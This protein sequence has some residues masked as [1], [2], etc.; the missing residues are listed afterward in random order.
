M[1]P[2]RKAA[3][4]SGLV[5][6]DDEDVMQMGANEDA[7]PQEPLDERPAKKPRGRPKSIPPKAEIPVRRSVTFAVKQEAPPKKHPGRG[8]RPRTAVAEPEPQAPKAGEDQ[9]AHDVSNAEDVGPDVSNDDLDSPEDTTMPKKPAG[10]G[11]RSASTSKQ[12]TADGEFVYTP[13]SSRPL[14][15][16]EGI[17]NRS[18][19]LLGKQQKSDAD[20]ITIVPETQEPAPEIDDTILTEE[21]PVNSRAKSVS[22]LK[23]RVNG[24]TTQRH[25]QETSR[26]RGPVASSDNEKT[27][28]DPDLRR[29]LG[30]MTKKYESLDAKYRN[31]RDIGIVEA[32]TNFEKLRKQCE[33]ATAGTIFLLLH[34][35]LR[36]NDMQRLPSLSLR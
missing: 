25:R 13:T 24:Q 20:E 7:S 10:R 21:E 5:E 3:K 26:K 23:A 19:R 11:R 36:A 28:S 27:T 17:E 9:N 4:I 18:K 1:P 31:L 15:P 6:S 2:K 33:A 29:K 34:S 32:N 12:I 16:Q 30:E 22:P 35:R 8:R 14:R